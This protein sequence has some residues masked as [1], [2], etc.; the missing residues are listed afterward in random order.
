MTAPTPLTPVQQALVVCGIWAVC[1][2][3]G[4][5]AERGYARFAAWR[6]RRREVRETIEELLRE[7]RV[8]SRWIIAE[9]KGRG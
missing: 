5:L 2:V 7:C 3:M 8:A 6:A 4:R 9:R 1:Y